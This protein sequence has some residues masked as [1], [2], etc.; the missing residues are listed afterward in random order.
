MTDIIL[1][2][3][4]YTTRL[5]VGRRE[6][7]SY[8]GVVRVRQQEETLGKGGVLLVETLWC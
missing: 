1:V 8:S 6:N 4:R 5:R 7:K 2:S 3:S